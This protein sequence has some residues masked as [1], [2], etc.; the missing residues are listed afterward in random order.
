MMPKLL[1]VLA[2]ALGCEGA[3]VEPVVDRDFAGCFWQTT[4][5]RGAGYYQCENADG[6]WKCDHKM[7]RASCVWT[8]PLP[9]GHPLQRNVERLASFRAV[10]H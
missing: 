1:L 6:L 2:F 9:A 10:G 5:D 8:G 4:G 7:D 3:G